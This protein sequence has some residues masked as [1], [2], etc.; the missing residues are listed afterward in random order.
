MN[1]AL[2]IKKTGLNSRKFVFV[3]AYWFVE[4]RLKKILSSRYFNPTIH[5]ILAGCLFVVT[6]HYADVADGLT[7]SVVSSK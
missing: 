4:S 3:I 2:R 6:Q 5:M 1:S 7:E